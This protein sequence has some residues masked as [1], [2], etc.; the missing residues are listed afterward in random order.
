MILNHVKFTK[1]INRSFPV[2]NSGLQKLVNYVYAARNMI[3]DPTYIHPSHPERRLDDMV[4]L[5]LF[6]LNNAP[7]Q[8]SIPP[9]PTIYGYGRYA[10]GHFEFPLPNKYANKLNNPLK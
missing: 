3:K 2:S 10:R 6:K 5:I 4:A 8:I 7:D 9:W 1:P